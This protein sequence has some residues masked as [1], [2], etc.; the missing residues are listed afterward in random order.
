MKTM[1]RPI[2]AAGILLFATAAFADDEHIFPRTG[3][4]YRMTYSALNPSTANDRPG[5]SDERS[6]NLK[7]LKVQSNGWIL[8]SEIYYEYPRSAPTPENPLGERMKPIRK[9]AQPIWYNLDSFSRASEMKE[10]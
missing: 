7:I 3:E 4:V 8:A 9:E 5:V 2:L 1:I 10:K 6:V